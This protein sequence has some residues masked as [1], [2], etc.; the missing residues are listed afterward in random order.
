MAVFVAKVEVKPHPLVAVRTLV[1]R[2]LSLI[3]SPLEGGPYVCGNPA[4]WQ[5]LWLIPPPLGG[6]VAIVAQLS[7][8]SQAEKICR[9]AFTRRLGLGRVASDGRQGFIRLR[10]SL[11]YHPKMGR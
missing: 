11:A 2:H 7:G 8:G 9:I 6:M 3:Q 1:C 10:D 5:R 4:A